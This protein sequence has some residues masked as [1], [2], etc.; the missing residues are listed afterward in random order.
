[1]PKS[2]ALTISKLQICTIQ[3]L[4]V[5]NQPL[6][7]TWDKLHTYRGMTNILDITIEQQFK[8]HKSQEKCYPYRSS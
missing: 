2:I 8:L 6:K 4:L 1:M 5:F 3:N 7:L